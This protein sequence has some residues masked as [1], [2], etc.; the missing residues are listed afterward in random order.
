MNKIIKKN[1][2]TLITFILP[3]ILILI[4]FLLHKDYG[5]SL[6]EEITRN[7]GLVSI[8]YIA[9]LFFPQYASNFE[10]IQNIPELK[11][12]SDKQ[13]GTFFEILVIFCL[14]VFRR[15]INKIAKKGKVF[16]FKQL[17]KIF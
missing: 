12:Y 3:L 9:D 4:G 7:N 10:L 2:I 13:Y 11:N 14:R 16:N 6:D 5:I 15:K 1:H 8:K 17:P